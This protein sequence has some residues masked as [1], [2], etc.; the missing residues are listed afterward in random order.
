MTE[1]TAK[2]LDG[3]TILDFTRV[4]AGPYCTAMLADQGASV[5]KVE[6]PQ[7]DDQRAMGAFRDGRSLSFELINRNKRS[8]RLDMRAP[9]GRAIAAGL[10][11]RADVVIENFRPGVA[12]RLGIGAA[13]L[14]AAHP[15]LIYCSISGF[16]Q[17]GPMA[18][19]PSY[20]V[21]AQALSGLMSI[22][23]AP[24][25]DPVLV[26]DSVGDILAGIYA[27][28]AISAALFR[29]ERT[30]AGATIDVA[31]FDA[32]FSLL[33]T[34]LA[35]WQRD[36]TPPRRAGADHPLSAP[37]GA[38]RAADG[39]VM[40][41]VGN[42]SLFGTLCAAMGRA[43][44]AGDP[45]FSS[46]QS[47]KAN[48]D[49]L[50]AQIEAWTGALPAAEVVRILSAAGVPVS[51]VWAVDEAAESAQVAARGLLHAVDHPERGRLM[52][53]EQPVHF[54]GS[55]RGAPRPAP[56]LGADGA[57]ILRDVLGLPQD[58]IARLRAADII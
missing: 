1:T 45:R 22:T 38:Y 47:R 10:A 11:A 3:I 53:P 36:G 49:A 31:M 57:A 55:P 8:L 24:E 29:R 28:Q 6:A 21:I 43:D 17:S 37:F 15:R 54:V 7:G 14:R 23:G 5:I 33:P 48:A 18:Q 9:E 27:A 51:P 44:M 30:G 4:L 32:L 12:E 13:A 52:L 50:R 35:I 16:G 25:G 34:A 20:D 2:P 19:M 40:I 26:G 39:R 46:D 56:D 58:E 41:A 42:T